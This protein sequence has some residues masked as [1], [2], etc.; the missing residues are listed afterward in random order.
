M[1]Q[2]ED[3]GLPKSPQNNGV[4]ALVFEIR[5]F[6]DRLLLEIFYYTTLNRN[7]DEVNVLNLT[8]LSTLGKLLKLMLFL[9]RGRTSLEKE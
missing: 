8:Q 3:Q 6:D 5:S 4:T 9:D 2:G 1:N 7:L